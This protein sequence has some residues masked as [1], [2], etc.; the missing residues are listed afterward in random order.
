MAFVKIDNNNFERITLN[1][2]PDVHFISSSI[3]MGVTGSSHVSPFRSQ[4]LKQELVFRE[5]TDDDGNIELVVDNENSPK[6]ALTEILAD[7]TN[8]DNKLDAYMGKV[9]AAS[10]IIKNTKT[11]DIFRFDQPVN[12]NKNRTIKNDTRKVM[13]P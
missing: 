9:N 4:V 3:G 6:N 2:K 7:Q 5:E 12:F 1:L 10:Q 8:L 11:V 13:M